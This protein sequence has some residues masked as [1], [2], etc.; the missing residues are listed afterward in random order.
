MPK[1][2][3]I[4]AQAEVEHGPMY[5][6]DKPWYMDEPLGEEGQ[7]LDE[8]GIT[9]SLCQHEL[10]VPAGMIVWME[11]NHPGRVYISGRD[12]YNWSDYNGY[13]PCVISWDFA[14]ELLSEGEGD[15]L[16]TL[17]IC[18]PLPAECVAEMAKAKMRRAANADL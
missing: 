18:K 12:M 9:I 3:A 7:G 1:T 4:I 17:E 8:E 14:V 10:S 16:W 2:T 5:V 15:G 6:W 11:C 13:D